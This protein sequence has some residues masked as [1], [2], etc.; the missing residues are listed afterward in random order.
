MAGALGKSPS[1]GP[2]ATRGGGASPPETIQRAETE[3]LELTPR[4]RRRLANLSRREF[5][6]PRTTAALVLP[7][8]VVAPAAP[9]GSKASDWE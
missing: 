9:A 4:E 7:A 2:G 6:G 5:G 3:M 8:L 1:G